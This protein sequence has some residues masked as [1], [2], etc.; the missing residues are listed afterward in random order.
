MQRWNLFVALMMIAGV[1]M[2]GCATTSNQTTDPLNGSSC[3]L[4]TLNGQAVLSEPIVTLNFKDGQIN[5]TDGC[6]SYSTSYT[7]DGN[8]I[9]INENIATTLMA[10]AE[11]IMQQATA[12]IAALTQAATYKIEGQQL[13]LFDKDGK[14]LATFTM[15][16]GEVSGTSWIVTG[17]NNGNQAVVS[18]IIDTELSADFGTDGKLSGSAGCNT[19]TSTYETSLENIKIGPAAS[20]RMMCAEPVGV[21]EQEAQ[22]LKA[23]ETAATYRLDGNTLELRTTDG[24]LAV[25]FTKAGTTAS[26]PLQSSESAAS[27]W[28]ALPNLGYPIEGISTGIAQLKDGLFEEQAAPASATK[29]KVQLGDLRSLGDLNGDGL[30]DAAVILVVDP[31][32]SGTFDYLA[33][34]TNE[35]G[36]AKPVASV[37]LGDRVIVKSIA[38]QSG[39]V[40]VTMLTRKPD[41]PMSTEPSVE[42]IRKFKLQ[43]DKLVE[44]N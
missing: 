34:V 24:A 23:L 36:A 16:S 17:Y 13:I 35:N 21:M 27:I 10:C 30:E 3:S 42:V 32:G 19:Y 37:L 14:E 15:K 20:T 6:N 8:K 33:L 5:G 7:V 44:V 12:Y 28:Q 4:A 11:P 43:G 38:I 22:Y 25:S 26:S 29:T 40:I 39:E 1:I 31:G 2:A 9:T 18:V 41:E